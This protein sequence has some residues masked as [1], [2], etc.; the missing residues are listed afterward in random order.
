MKRIFLGLVFA[1]IALACAFGQTH[2]YEHTETVDANGVR[3][4]GTAGGMYLTFSNNRNVVYES[5]KDGHG[6]TKTWW[7]DNPSI[8]S[9]TNVP[10]VE[11]YRYKNRQNDLHVFEFDA[12]S[13]CANESKNR[14]V[15]GN[16]YFTLSWYDVCIQNMV[17]TTG[18]LKQYSTRYHYWYFNSD[19]SRMNIPLS[20][21]RTQVWVRTTP[22]ADRG[23]APAQFY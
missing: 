7:R 15:Q 5:D 16:P 19:Y 6:K 23:T 8:G 13:V 18:Y 9:G 3:T 1:G 10:Y 4:K 22:P 11:T 17:G 12:H 2:Y 21:N 20:G 14:I